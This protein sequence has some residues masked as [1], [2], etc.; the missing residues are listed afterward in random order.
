[1]PPCAS[2]RAHQVKTKKRCP[3]QLWDK[4]R[5]LARNGLKRKL[6][7]DEGG[8]KIPIARLK[9]LRITQG[10]AAPAPPPTIL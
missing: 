1:M 10:E 4:V 6:D 3:K 5:T 2:R 7:V 9:R 8:A